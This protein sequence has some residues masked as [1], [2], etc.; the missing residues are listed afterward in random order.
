[1]P[2]PPQYSHKELCWYTPGLLKSPA[3][4]QAG[5]VPGTPFYSAFA[6]STSTS[7][8]KFPEAVS[9][10]LLRSA[11]A[12]LVLVLPPAQQS[13]QRVHSRCPAHRPPCSDSTLRGS[14]VSPDPAHST[15]KHFLRKGPSADIC[16]ST[17]TH[18]HMS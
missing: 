5:P 17:H 10:Q 6:S 9:L 12:P 3:L 15:E 16:T 8:V 11:P 1:M 13:T 14:S 18:V 2:L 4:V 7:S